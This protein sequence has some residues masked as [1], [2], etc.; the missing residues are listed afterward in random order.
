MSLKKQKRATNSAK[1]HGDITNETRKTIR[2]LENMT[3]TSFLRTIIIVLS[4]SAIIGCKQEGCTD[5]DSL[6]FSS[7]ADEDD[8]SCVFEASAVFWH[9]QAAS[10]SLLSNNVTT[11]TYYV[12]DTSVGSNAST[13]FWTSAP[14]CGGN[15]SLSITERL[16]RA[17][18]KNFD[19]RIEDQNGN[20]L[21]E[22]QL[23][24][25]ANSCE[26]VQFIP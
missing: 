15:G 7:R 17:K 26:A 11:L 14:G 4:F 1:K 12:D 18:T 16:G 8:G 5:S 2:T 23:T 13:T 25:S 24:M 6:N 21:E 10:D 22:G 3:S 9:D 19:Y 20:L